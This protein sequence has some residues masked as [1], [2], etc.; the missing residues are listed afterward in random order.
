[1]SVTK[2]RNMKLVVVIMTALIAT[3][4]Y[5]QSADD[6]RRL[7]EFKKKVNL[8]VVLPK[9]EKVK[10][11]VTRELVYNPVKDTSQK[12]DVYQPT[13]D[14]SKEKLPL[15]IFVHGK[16]P[17]QTNPKNWGGYK[18]WAEL[19]ASKGYVAI[20]FTQSLAT[21]GRSIED[22][23]SDLQ[24]ALVYIKA[25][26]SLYNIDTNRIALL[27]Y[28]AGVPLLSGALLHNQNNIKC[29]AAFYGFMDIKN[30]DMWKSESQTTLLN[31]S[32]IDYVN[33]GKK[34][35]PLFIAK[36]GKENNKGLNETIDSF[37]LKANSSNINV[38]LINH[39][40]GVHGFDTQNNDDRSREVIESMLIFL[41]YHLR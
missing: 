36:A 2:K 37:M 27:A 31:F 20:T 33:T 1:M 34:F 15:V 7:E 32:L 30:I 35:P 8:P 28:S 40:T 12:L 24:D 10:I 39:P 11:K 19:I 21:P 25:N 29:L 9:N 3:I 22:A 16:T 17:I 4:G 13:S 38:T 41:Q 14:L 6:L 18:S 5:G 26:H 23:G